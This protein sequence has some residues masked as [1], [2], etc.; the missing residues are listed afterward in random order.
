M[1]SP[2]LLGPFQVTFNEPATSTVDAASSV[3]ATSVTASGVFAST[4]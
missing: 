3:A 4:G 1:K 2:W